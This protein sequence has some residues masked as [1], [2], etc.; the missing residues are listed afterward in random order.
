MT[1]LTPLIKNDDSM[2]L[3]K[4]NLDGKIKSS[5]ENY[6]EVSLFIE[7]LFAFPNIFGY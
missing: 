4:Q 1:N 7:K 2:L 6:S 3:N 5:S